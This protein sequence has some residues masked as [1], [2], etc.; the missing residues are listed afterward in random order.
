ML[1]IEVFESFCVTF[2]TNQNFKGLC[3]KSKQTYL[4]LT[5]APVLLL[6][7]CKWFGGTEKAMTPGVAAVKDGKPMPGGV[8]ATWA[9]GSA[10]VMQ[11]EFD[12]MLDLMMKGKP[13]LQGLPEAFLPMVKTQ[14][15]NSMVSYKIIDK[16]V[17]ENKLDQAKD[18]KQKFEMALKNATTAVNVDTFMGALDLATSEGDYRDYY[19]KNKDKVALVSMGGVKAEGVK[20]ETEADAKAFLAKAKGADFAKLVQAD[21]N[22]KNNLQDFQ[23]VNDKSRINKSLKDAILAIRRFPSVIM[24]KESDKIFWVVNATE[25]TETKYRS[26]EEL[27]DQIENTVKQTKQQEVLM[28]KIEELKGAYG[29]NVKEG[30]FMPKQ[31]QAPAQAPQAMVPTGEPMPKAQK[32]KRKK[33]AAKP[34]KPVAKAA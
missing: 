26:Y 24:V 8:L 29:V 16:W 22:I 27:K 1:S 12:E 31:P 14:L 2:L 13:E 6:S 15:L 20:F 21:E 5:L 34:I 7:G 3:M 25:K 30:A 33:E 17:K 23:Y 9:D 11:K 19:E 4:V 32:G 18:Y 10:M 28:K